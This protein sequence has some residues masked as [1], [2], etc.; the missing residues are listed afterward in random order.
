M[1]LKIREW[2]IK[3]AASLGW[4]NSYEITEKTVN[5]IVDQQK[6]VNEDIVPQ[7]DIIVLT[8]FVVVKGLDY[9][10]DTLKE[11]EYIWFLKCETG[12][13]GILIAVNKDMVDEEKLLK[14]KKEKLYNR[15]A[16]FSSD[17]GC[18]ILRVDLPLK[19]CKYSRLTVIGCRMETGDKIL[20]EQ[21]D[22]ERKCFDEVLIPMI[23]T[24]EGLCIICGDFNN[25]KCYGN[26]NKRFNFND[27]KIKN[28]PGYV[29]QF[30][31][32]LH[33]IKDKLEALNFSMMDVTKDGNPIPTHNG[34]AEDHIFVR[35]FNKFVRGSNKEGCNCI[36]ADGLSDHD[37]IWAT[38]KT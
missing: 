1:E 22:S 7:P 12:K 37:I 4:N 6:S 25:A 33:I 11:N 2:N 14:D 10:F 5:K 18:N 24:A 17:D 21:Y 23:N 20:K 34:Y 30:N 27:Y 8:E 13:N 35:G 28:E 3:G 26:L 32:N 36:P 9:L 38:V 19:G 16:I 31:Y 15:K 29:A